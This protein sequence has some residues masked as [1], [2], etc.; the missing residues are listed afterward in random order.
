[1]QRIYQKIAILLVISTIG[2]TTNGYTQ[3]IDTNI[4]NGSVDKQSYTV[5]GVTISGGQYLDTSVIKTIFG[6]TKGDEVI[7]PNDEKI[8][9][10]LYTLFEQDVKQSSELTPERYAER[11]LWIKFKEGISRLL[12]PVL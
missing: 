10:E 1:M 12:S 4:I 9:K 2:F 6:I 3:A 5:G 11:S 8:A 7:L